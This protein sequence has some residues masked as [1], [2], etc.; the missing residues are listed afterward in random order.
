[1]CC[2]SICHHSTSQEVVFEKVIR[3]QQH[4]CHHHGSVCCWDHALQQYTTHH[5]LV[6][7]SSHSPCRAHA[8]PLPCRSDGKIWHNS[9]FLNTQRLRHFAYEPANTSTLN[10]QKSP[11]PIQPT[12][13]TSVGL[14]MAEA[15]APLVIPARIFFSTVSSGCDNRGDYN[16]SYQCYSPPGF[17]FFRWWYMPILSVP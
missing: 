4:S 11:T 5:T 13:N 2:G 6:K 17:I 9:F 10:A 14:A 7:R 3:R 8:S 16:P 1:M 12:F 15:T